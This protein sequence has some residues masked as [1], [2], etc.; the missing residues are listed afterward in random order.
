MP[1]HILLKPGPLTPGEQVIMRQHAEFGRK[2]IHSTA[3]QIEGDNFLQ[4]AGEIAAT[5]HEKWDGTGYPEGL[6]GQAIPLAGRIM[7]VADIYDALISRRCYKDP[8][9]H[10]R[11]KTL[12][13][14][15]GGQDVRS[16]RA[17][18]LLRDRGGSPADRGPL[19]RRKPRYR[20]VGRVDDLVGTPFGR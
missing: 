16:G 11:A 8:F 5:H 9:P 17:G 1:D 20:R 4:V 6:R 19:P 2:I 3:Q 7:A 13:R 12:M 14:D 18:S 15:L 10:A